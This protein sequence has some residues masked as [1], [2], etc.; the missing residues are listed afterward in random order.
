[1]AEDSTPYAASILRAAFFSRSALEVAPELLNCRIV[2]DID[3]DV[4]VLRITEVEAYLGVGEDPGSHAFRG[5][6]ARNESMFLPGGALYVYRSYGIHWC[7]N[8]VTGAAGE[9][10]GVLLRAGE[11]VVG[12]D[13]AYARRV[14]SGVVRRDIDLARGPGRLATSLGLSDRFDGSS[15]TA[16]G[17]V[18]IQL[19]TSDSVP[20]E[21]N[22]GRSTRTGVSGIGSHAEFRFY[23]KEDPTVSP[24][25]PVRHEIMPASAPD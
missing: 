2:T 21:V 20:S 8:V 9:A 23:L 3:G 1:M 6:T 5:R 22:V 13:I 16:R 10:S 25:K 18:S 11:V 7:A 14:A 24:H 17:P 15:L 19:P 4:V 12:R